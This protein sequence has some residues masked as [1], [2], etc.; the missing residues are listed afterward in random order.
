MAQSLEIDDRVET[1]ASRTPY[2]T[3]KDHK[4]NFRN[5]PQCRLINPTKSE[6]G[7]VSKIILERINKKLLQ[8]TKVQQW[9]NT[10]A[11][12][13]WFDN[14]TGKQDC[15]FIS[16]D[17]VNFYPSIGQTTLDNS[18]KFASR[19]TNITTEEKCIIDHARQ[20]LLFTDNEPWIKKT[21]NSMFDVTMGSYDGAEVCELV[22]LFILNQLPTDTKHR[23]GLYRDDGLAILKDQPRQVENLKKKICEIFRKNG[24]NI[25]IEANK[26]IVNFLD[27]TLNLQDGTYKPYT[28]PANIPLYIHKS[29]NHPP[30]ILKN[31]PLAINNRLSTISS[32]EK[33]F[34][35][36]C[37]VYQEALDR[38]GYTHK[39]KFNKPPTKSHE[40]PTRKRNIVWFNPPFSKSVGLDMGR[41]FLNSVK[42]TFTTDHPLRKIF[43]KNTIKLSYCCTQNMQATISAD[44]SKKL[45]LEASVPDQ[46]RTNNCNCRD[47]ANCPM[48]GDC[49]STN[50]IYQ[51]TVKED[52]G[53]TETYIGLTETS[54]KT[55]YN[56]HKLSFNNKKYSN[57]TELS[58]HITRLKEQQ[59]T[60][61]LT[62]KIVA[63]AKPYN[64]ITK[65]CNLCTTEK[66]FIIYK[67]NMGSL[68]KRDELASTCR[69]TNKYILR[70][71]K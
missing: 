49:L 51:A 29:S 7:K 22:G 5:N 2:I 58:K 19:Y 57:S 4:E 69:H 6:L 54:F 24:F 33:C 15:T 23:I 35:S 64:P 47:R 31:I 10:N 71:F 62:W 28:K 20:S 37:K 26:K 63:R 50:V 66:Y 36:E 32:N 48:D 21:G 70:N 40:K 61:T 65:R 12:L 59:K 44:N 17:I 41:K 60:Y 55:R 11:V 25:T 9:K 53:N 30:S 39:L 16:F 56:N 67:R 3:L 46:Q 13:Q 68:N 27:V 1:I 8:A 43:N 38:S 52:E 34:D 42:D 18:I 14:T 45:T